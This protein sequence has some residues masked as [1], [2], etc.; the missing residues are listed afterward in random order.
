MYMQT[1][2]VNFFFFKVYQIC[3][4]FKKKIVSLHLGKSYTTSSCWT[5]PGLE[6]SKG[7]MVERCDISSLPF[8]DKESDFYSK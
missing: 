1:F 3:I 5:P 8:F 7:K 6:D 2:A 4:L